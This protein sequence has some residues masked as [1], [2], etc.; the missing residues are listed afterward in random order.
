[1]RLKLTVAE[2]KLDQG[3]PVHGEGIDPDL[4]L[5]RVVFN[6]SGAWIPPDPDAGVPSIIDAE[7]RKG[8]RAEGAADLEVDP[9]MALGKRLVLS[10]RGP[11]RTDV[12]GAMETLAPTLTLAAEKRVMDMFRHRDLDWTPSDDAMGIVDA[13]V[14]VSLLG[15]ARAGERVELQ[16]EIVNNG[17]APLYR[18]RVRLDAASARLPW[19]NVTIPL[20]FVPPGE[21][22]LGTTQV[23]IP[24]QGPGRIDAV[25]M[26]L[27]ADGLDP[28][29]LDKVMLGFDGLD[30]PPMAALVTLSP[31]GDHHRVEV[32]LE[33]LGPVTLTGVRVRFAWRDDSG[34]ELLDREALL[35]ALGPEER[36]RVD[37]ALRVLDEE[38]AEDILLELRV[39]AERFQ[40]LIRVPVTIPRDGSTFRV[41]PPKLDVDAPVRTDADEVSVRFTAEDD[42]SIES[43][44]VW[45]RGGKHAWM[46]GEGRRLSEDLHLPVEPGSNRLTI[47]A[48]DDDGNETRAY[49]YIWSDKPPADAA[50]DGTSS[51]GQDA[52]AE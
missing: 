15:E 3:Q 2:Y 52:V 27:E 41:Q 10:T 29:E 36:A 21:R 37:L 31:H 13:D 25:E 17:P 45:W 20:G 12:L 18:A 7:E 5:R 50:V 46:R 44:T 19:D 30:A 14:V 39:D 6:R 26:Q 34:V 49:R 35:P 47:V 42:E 1:V 16:A 43:V 22:A 32:G 8:W 28:V 40:G 23:A 4:I 33:N 38:S 11:S 51:T 48:M 24:M 9:L